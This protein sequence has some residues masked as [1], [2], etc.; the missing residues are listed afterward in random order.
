MR[1]VVFHLG[2]D[3]TLIAKPKTS[4]SSVNETLFREMWNSSTV[5]LCKIRELRRERPKRFQFLAHHGVQAR[6]ITTEKRRKWTSAVNQIDITEVKLA[7]DCVWGR[8][9]VSGT[10]SPRPRRG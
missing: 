1:I 6:L 3:A 10:A 8:H 7:D 2:R 5:L 9:F 4:R